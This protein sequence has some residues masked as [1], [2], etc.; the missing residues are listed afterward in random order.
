MSEQSETLETLVCKGRTKEAI[1]QLKSLIE[2][3]NKEHLTNLIALSGRYYTNNKVEGAGTEE[4]KT[5]NMESNR[6]RFQ[7]LSILVP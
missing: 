2:T 3:L 1:E 7:F 5:T 4:A 6:I